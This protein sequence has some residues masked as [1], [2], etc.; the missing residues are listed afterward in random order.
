MQGHKAFKVQSCAMRSSLLLVGNVVSFG[1]VPIG[2]PRVLLL[3]S[4]TEK[5]AECA[6]AKAV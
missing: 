3:F 2:Q 1:I 4:G 6:M 5:D